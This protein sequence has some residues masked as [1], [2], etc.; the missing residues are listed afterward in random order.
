MDPTGPETGE[1][2]VRRGGNR[3]QDTRFLTVSYRDVEETELSLTGFRLAMDAP[4]IK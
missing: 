4:K 1:F 2:H 3:G